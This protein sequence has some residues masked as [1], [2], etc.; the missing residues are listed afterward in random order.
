MAF[1]GG[2]GPP[3]PPPHPSRLFYKSMKYN[4]FMEFNFAIVRLHA[5]KFTS[6]VSV[7]VS[8]GCDGEARACWTMRPCMVGVQARTR[9]G[10]VAISLRCCPPTRRFRRWSTMRPFL[11]RRYRRY[12]RNF[13]G[14]LPYR[15][16]ASNS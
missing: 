13:G 4:N 10:G 12:G 15:P 8:G 9:P 6:K 14:E 2:T 7:E 3:T 16:D 11:G 1:G 5:P